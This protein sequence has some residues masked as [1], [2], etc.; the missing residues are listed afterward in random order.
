[1]TW[2]HYVKILDTR[3]EPGWEFFTYEILEGEN[4]GEI[5]TRGHSHDLDATMHSE[6]MIGQETLIRLSRNGKHLEK[7][8]PGR[9]FVDKVSLSMMKMI[10]EPY[11]ELRKERN[12][13]GRNNLVG[14]TPWDGQ[15]PALGVIIW[16]DG[17]YHWRGINKRIEFD[18]NKVSFGTE[19]PFSIVEASALKQLRD[20]VDHPG[21]PKEAI[22]TGGWSSKGKTTFTYDVE[23][24]DL[25]TLFGGLRNLLTE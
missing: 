12:R 5:I 6:R 21:I 23:D 10:G 22:I 14:A 15:R 16:K 3:N 8:H 11:E 9:M 7:V 19:V 2:T 17:R 13:A 24:I 4:R 20:V 1:M 25:E 18:E